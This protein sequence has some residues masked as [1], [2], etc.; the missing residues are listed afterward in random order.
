M[1]TQKIAVLMGGWSLERDVSLAS[2]HSVVA[3]LRQLGHDVLPIDVTADLQKLIGTLEDY[4]P[5]VVFNALH[6]VGGEDGVIQGVLETMRLPYTHSGVLA[7]AVAMNKVTSRKIFQSAGIPVP[8][9]KVVT[10]DAFRKEHP[11]AVP[12]VVKPI[13]EGSSKGVFIV[14][15][16][17]DWEEVGKNWSFQ[18]DLLIE[19]FI[20]GREIQV[21][22]MGDKAIGAIEIRPL[23]DF[24]DYEAKYTDGKAEHIMPAPLKP[25]AYDNVLQLS[26]RAH[27][28]LG[29]RGVTRS[30]FM[31]DE[32]ENVFYLLELNTQ[33]GMTDLSLVPEI[34]A[35]QGISFPQ[36]CHWMVEQAQCGH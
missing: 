24:Y 6:G 13:S 7:S 33:P 35:H 12:Y 26:L 14:R 11:M 27:E 8:V 19:K 30:D 36:L 4:K 1:K 2:G 34:A 10:L 28:A 32:S 15:C 3:A 25:D 21:G 16:D 18:S 20:E 31:Y 22:I 23:N 9:S 29:C 5:D 17:A